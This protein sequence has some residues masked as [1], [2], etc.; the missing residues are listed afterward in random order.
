MSGE[1]IVP[2]K[3][4]GIGLSEPTLP[5]ESTVEYQQGLVQLIEE[6][7]ATTVLQIYL[8]EKIYDCLWW[9]QR[10]QQQK[11]M[12]LTM[13]MARQLQNDILRGD[14]TSSGAKL[15]EDLVAG[16]MSGRLKSA[17]KE[18]NHTLDSLRQAAYTKKASN[19]RYLDDQIALQAKILAGF[20]ASY[21]VAS[22]RKLVSEKLT[23]QNQLLRK[24]LGAIDGE[25][26][27]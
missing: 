26:E 25:V 3:S 5:G 13:E 22:N 15:R 14:L 9:I 23:L 16:Q 12:I 10:Y 19:L 4:S 11:R 18:N 6:L 8:A 7:E 24:D 27:P 1:K 20:Q 17:L 21:E 2:S